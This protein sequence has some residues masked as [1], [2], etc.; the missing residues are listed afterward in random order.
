MSINKVAVIGSGVMGS[1]IAAQIANAGHQVVLLDIVPPDLAKFG[2][3]R[4]AFA[5]GAIEKMLKTDPA[6]FMSARNAKL[7]TAGNI[8]DDLALLS[9]CDWIIEVVLEDLK[10]KHETY[11]K[12]DAHR[13]KGSIV[14]S[15]TSTIP[16]HNLIEGQSAEF[17]SDFLIT[18]FF[19]PPRYMRLLELV[20]G[21]KTRADAIEDVRAFCDVKLGKGVVECNDTPGFIANRLG[22]FWLTAGI[23]EAINLGVTVEQ[24]DAVMSKPVGIPKTGVFGLVDLVGVDLM[25][26]LS[27]SLLST[28]PQDDRYRAIFKDFG[29][30]H[31]MIKAGYTGRKGKG[32]FYRINPENPKAKE[33][34]AL[35]ITA[36][37]FDEA[38]YKK[39]DKPELASVNAAKGGLR[40][41][42]ESDDIG[43]KYAWKVLAQTLHYAASL[44]PEIAGNIADVDEAMRLGYNWKSGPFEMIDAL[45]AQWFAEKLAAEGL[46]VPD[47][48]KKVGS[49]TFYK[50]EGGKRFYFGVDGQ[51]QEIKRADGVLL[52]ADLKLSQE[53]ILKNPSA[54]VWDIG[55]GVLCFEKTSK[56]NTFDELIFEMFEKVIALIGDGK[57]KYKA[58]VIYNEGS[59]FS[60]GANLGMAVGLIKEGNFPQVEKFIAAGQRVFM[61]LKYA[62]FPVVAAPS[63]VALGGGCEVVL[64]ANAVQAHAET[65]I[66]LVEVGVGLIPGWG[67]CKE[68]ILRFRERERKKF[69]KDL[70]KIGKDQ[71]WFSPDITPMGATR[72]A[73]EVIG[74]ATVSK[75]AVNA[76]ELGYFRESDG[77]TMNRDRLLYDAKARALSMAKDYNA[78]EPVAEIRMPG[79][80]GRAALDMAV[81]D[82][83]KA[84]KAT[85]YDVVVCGHLSEVLSGGKNADW[86]KPISEADILKLEIDEFAYLIRSEGTVARID[87]ML[88][89][90]KPLR[91]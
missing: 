77:I 67:G 35:S 29:F 11:K 43:G 80:A 47:L 20:T 48:L 87:H 18:H 25:P 91:N 68:L 37:S 82:L 39:A 65:Y 4:S 75:S 44:V 10:V 63:G 57:G 78:G 51:Y 83:V 88:A 16:L 64:A 14:S 27:H 54:S 8:E 2:G 15:N 66:G 61:A 3:D 81:Q 62:P 33:K 23:N 28:L 56:M 31:G 9:D 60:A 71:M 22:V 1:G 72:K 13:K 30:I 6:P 49:G 79:P 53:P 21:E 76:I 89:T 38:Q 59:A 45:G 58:L 55:E 69:K 52:L 84:G 41:V 7:I 46:D 19:N 17:A 85:P 36:D 86:T 74:V 40:A 12:I 42:V 26:H 73:F 32:G 24:A 90:G 70:G 50:I 34:Q 5:K